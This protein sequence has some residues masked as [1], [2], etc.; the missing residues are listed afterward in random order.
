MEDLIVPAEKPDY[1]RPRGNV[2]CRRYDFLGEREP[3]FEELQVTFHGSISFIVRSKA[4][5][6][7]K[8]IRVQSPDFGKTWHT[9]PL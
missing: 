2:D 8:S 7:G 3:R 9:A 4:I 1:C 5:R 6:N